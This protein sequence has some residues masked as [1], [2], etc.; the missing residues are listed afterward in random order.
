MM[1]RRRTPIIFMSACLLAI[2]Y[3]KLLQKN[4]GAFR[5]NHKILE[6]C[7]LEKPKT[8][9]FKLVALM[10]A[11]YNAWNNH[12]FNRKNSKTI[13]LQNFI[14][15][16]CKTIHTLHVSSFCS[17]KLFFFLLLCRSVATNP[18]S[19]M[20]HSL[21]LYAIFPLNVQ[22]LNSPTKRKC[23]SSMGA[24]GKQLDRVVGMGLEDNL[25]SMQIFDTP[26]LSGDPQ[27]RITF[28]QNQLHQDSLL[29][30]RKVQCLM[31]L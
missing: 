23:L 1:D 4:M 18:T 13:N 7:K 17:A 29:G 11:Y 16:A 28:N 5:F 6:S 10:A 3:Y 24:C 30:V 8:S 22:N 2:E 25:Q 31:A 12:C 9:N 26:C 21:W 15:S 14:L 27:T 19:R 20:K